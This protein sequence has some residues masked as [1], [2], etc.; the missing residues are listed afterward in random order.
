MNRES[1]AYGESYNHFVALFNLR[2]KLSRFNLVDLESDRIYQI[3]GPS[4]GF[5]R[6][7]FL[8]M[9]A[10]MQPCMQVMRQDLSQSMHLM[11]CSRPQRVS[12]SSDL[13]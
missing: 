9:H 3:S 4:Y 7:A 2:T 8:I 12:S 6:T 10:V 5:V 11:L 1:R 13:Y